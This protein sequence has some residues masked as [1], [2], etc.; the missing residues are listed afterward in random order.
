MLY[1]QRVL[2]RN[3]LHYAEC[4][5]FVICITDLI[6]LKIVLVEEPG[7]A[8]KRGCLEQIWNRL[9]L[10]RSCQSELDHQ[11]DCHGPLNSLFYDSIPSQYC[12]HI[13]ATSDPSPQLCQTTL[14]PSPL[15]S[16]YARFFSIYEIC[17]FLSSLFTDTDNNY[18]V[19]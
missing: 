18:R 4:E 14:I 3:Q 12:S 7:A 19:R 9:E 11:F 16:F 13:L 5:S 1:I 10:I 17:G 2:F 6:A 8:A 15:P